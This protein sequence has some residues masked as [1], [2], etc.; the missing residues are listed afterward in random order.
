MNILFGIITTTASIII[1]WMLYLCVPRQY[2]SKARPYF[3]LGT[4]AIAFLVAWSSAMTY[5]PRVELSSSQSYAL[6]EKQP[7]MPGKDIFDSENKWKRF[8]ETAGKHQVRQGKAEINPDNEGRE[9]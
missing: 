4:A 1:L 7:I 8:D 9:P 5:S 3:W 2:R 6:P